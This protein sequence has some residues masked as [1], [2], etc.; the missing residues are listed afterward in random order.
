M[1]SEI[2]EARKAAGLYAWQLAEAAGTTE[3]RY[4]QIERGR[5]RPRP[6]EGRRLAVALGRDA[7]ALFP[8]GFNDRGGR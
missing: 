4:Y 7:A 5:M 1:N 3:N 8:D 6:D 2:R